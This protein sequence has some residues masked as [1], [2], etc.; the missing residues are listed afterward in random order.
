MA[1][2][3]DKKISDLETRKQNL[4]I[5]V[6]NEIKSDYNQKIVEILENPFDERDSEVALYLLKQLK[7]YHSKIKEIDQQIEHL[8][9]ILKDIDKKIDF[10]KERKERIR[11][12]PLER[13]TEKSIA[14]TFK[15]DTVYQYAKEIW[16]EELIKK[17]EKRSLSAKK[18]TEIL[19]KDYRKHIETMYKNLFV[20]VSP[21]QKSNLE[22]SRKKETNLPNWMIEKIRKDLKDNK[23]LTVGSIE[24]FLK[25]ELKKNDWIIRVA[26]IKSKFPFNYNEALKYISGLIINYSEFSLTD[27]NKYEEK[28]SKKKNKSKHEKLKASVSKEELADSIYQR[29]DIENLLVK[30]FE[31]KDSDSLELR[32]SK[33]IDLFEE[34]WYK[35]SDRKSFEKELKETINT[36]APFR[37]EKDIQKILVF[38]INWTNCFENVGTYYTFKLNCWRRIMWYP[39]WEIFTICS[40][41]DYDDIRENVKPPKDKTI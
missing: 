27:D 13:D 22:Q 9:E 30:L 16:D 34:L 1:I 4:N 31:I 26:H 7:E 20:S 40:H 17:L 36:H 19:E 35:F 5:S 15:W 37:I 33:Y 24:S 11:N 2:S 10:Y 28:T 23:D 41:T 12:I 38:T 32:I 6:L 14:E 3:F 21:N 39:N 8:P 29:Q 18:Y 25:K